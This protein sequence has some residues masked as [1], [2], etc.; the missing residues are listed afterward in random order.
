M[1]RDVQLR[2]GWQ[3]RSVGRKTT[4]GTSSERVWNRVTLYSLD[5]SAA[6]PPENGL[7]TPPNGHGSHTH[8]PGATMER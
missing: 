3:R 7:D 5:D 4:S 8:R 6:G 1:F 2:E